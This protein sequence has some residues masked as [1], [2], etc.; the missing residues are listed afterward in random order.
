MRFHD[1]AEFTAE[2]VVFSLERAMTEDSGMKEL[3]ASVKE[4]RARDDHT[5]EIVTDGPNP[6]M[7]NNLTNMFIMARDW[8]EANDT[9]DVQDYE[10]DEDTY[11]AKNANGT[12][13]YRLAGR[14]TDVRTVLEANEDYPSLTGRSRGWRAK[15]TLRPETRRSPRSGASSRTRRCTCR[16]TARC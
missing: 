14:E 7:L 11:A 4:V 15:P 5:V 6:I 2:D 13:P 16:S 1:G 8:S 12:D 9:V 10:G 3:L